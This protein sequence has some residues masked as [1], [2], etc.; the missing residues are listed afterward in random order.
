MTGNQSVQLLGG[1]TLIPTGCLLSKSV[2]G[3]HA[4][5]NM[6]PTSLVSSQKAITFPLVLYQAKRVA[7]YLSQTVYMQSMLEA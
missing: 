2:M 6:K 3:H 4:Q 7:C 1:L 5:H